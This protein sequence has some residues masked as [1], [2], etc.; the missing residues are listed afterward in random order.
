MYKKEHQQ[1]GMTDIIIE[2]DAKICI[3]ALLGKSPTIP[4]KIQPLISN[5]KSLA[6]IF[7]SVEFCW[8]SRN[9]NI[10]AHCLVIFATSHPKSFLC[11]FSNFSLSIYEAWFRDLNF[12]N[13]I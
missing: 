1:E 3:D 2:R 5:A 8:V 12:L 7:F 6:L 13:S 9:A 4:R 11:N 10:V